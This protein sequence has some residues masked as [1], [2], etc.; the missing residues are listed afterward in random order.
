MRLDI[1][2]KK[3]LRK[4][5]VAWILL[6]AYNKMWEERE[7]KERN[8]RQKGRFGSWE[9]SQPLQGNTWDVAALVYLSERGRFPAGEEFCLRMNHALT[10]TH[11]WLRW[12]TDGTLD[13]DFRVGSGPGEDF[14]DC[15]DGMIVFRM[16]E[17]H[18]LG[19]SRGGMLWIECLCPS[20]S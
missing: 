1:Q 17:R 11:V 12:F 20:K 7:T 10:R 16:R 19:V 14:W 5:G 8:V 3:F 18:E 9:N 15:R 4:E 13:F 2:Q 6:T